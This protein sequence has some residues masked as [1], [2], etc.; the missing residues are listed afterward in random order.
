MKSNLRNKWLFVAAAILFSTAVVGYSQESPTITTIKKTTTHYNR[1]Y[2]VN[3]E[4]DYLKAL[5]GTDYL[6][7]NVSIETMG[8]NLRLV[9]CERCDSNSS[10]F[11][12]MS[13][14]TLM[15]SGQPSPIDGVS[16]L[17]IVLWLE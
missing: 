6:E 13:G 12:H 7:I 15:D 5:A 10:V 16:P 14:P 8:K 3:I 4:Y 1:S 17:S 9:S 2:T 11:S